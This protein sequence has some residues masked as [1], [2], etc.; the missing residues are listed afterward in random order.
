MDQLAQASM[1]TRSIAV[2]PFVN[3]SNDRENEYFSDG[4]TEEIINALTRIP[5][6]KVIARTS[7]FAFKGKNED[8]RSIGEQ[9]G[10]ASILEGS[11]RKSQKRIRITAQL[12]ETRGGTHLWSKNYDRELEDIFAVQDEI[13]LLIADQIRENFGH[14]VISE[15]L[16]IPPKISSENY[17]RFL[18]GRYCVQLFNP[19]QV[20]EGISILERVIEESPGFALAYVSIHYG[21]NILAAAGLMPMQEALSTGKAYLDRAIALDHQ[22]PEAFHSLGWHSLNQDWDFKSSEAYLLKAIK[23]R[24]GYA[25][26]HQ[27]LFISLALEGHLSQAFYHI[28]QALELDPLS[29]LSNYFMSYYYYLVRDFENTSYYFERT[30]ELDPRFLVGYSIYALALI[31]QGRTEEILQVTNLIP[32]MEGARVERLIMRALAEAATTVTEND[33]LTLKLMHAELTG[34]S[35][36]RV[37]FFLIYVELLRGNPERALTHIQNG[38]PNRE[39][40]LTLLKVDPVLKPLHTFPAFQAA[41]DIIYAHSRSS[42][43]L[44]KSYSSP[45]LTKE[46]AS[47][48]LGN[49]QAFMQAERPYLEADLSLRSLAA[50][51]ELHPNKLS[52]LINDRIG[53]NFNEYV[54]TFRLDAFKEKALN[55]ANRHLTLLAL[56][57]ESG[58]N[59]KTV[60]N[61][62]FK[63]KEGMPPRAW[64]KA[65]TV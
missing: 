50:N 43:A 54:N 13:S 37:R 3:M 46:E 4:I 49:L 38:I 16:V 61:E 47:E 5:G 59:S 44:K 15:A 48:E 19:E 64:L 18:K 25:E 22:L 41:L 28:Q 12:I 39:P 21:Y 53:K 26:A 24:P 14:L 9:L 63:K 40:L 56:A 58:F 7:S 65:Q 52:W 32:E 17:Q 10:V 6:L 45:L 60:F 62:F 55:P 51:I 29:P 35:R 23:L 11:V 42:K 1:E 34:P 27:K 30:F 36:E 33:S 57:F 8:V 31:S 2:L 20:K